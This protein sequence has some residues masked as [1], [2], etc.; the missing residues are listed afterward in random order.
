MWWPTMPVRGVPDAPATSTS[1]WQD[2]SLHSHGSNLFRCEH[3]PAF[4]AH[5]KLFQHGAHPCPSGMQ[6]LACNNPACRHGRP[7]MS[8]CSRLLHT[9]WHCRWLPLLPALLRQAASTGKMGRSCAPLAQRVDHDACVLHDVLPCV[10]HRQFA[11][12]PCALQF[13]DLA[14]CQDTSGAHDTRCCGHRQ[15]CQRQPASCT[16]MQA[17]GTAPHGAMQWLAGSRHEL[18]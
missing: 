3:E 2:R 18:Q 12:I 13:P 16:C 6:T 14:S 9:S 11:H 5:R 4:C 1:A 10:A 8:A 7:V 17:H 15:A